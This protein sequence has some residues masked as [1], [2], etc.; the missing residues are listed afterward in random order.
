MVAKKKSRIVKKAVP[1]PKDAGV[2]IDPRTDFGFKRLFGE[3]DLM[4]AFLNSVL[5][6]KDGI[7]DLEYRNTVRTGVSKDERETI[8][9]LY[10]ST[11]TGEQI[12]VEMQTIPHEHFID[13]V[14]YYVSRLIQQQGKK[15]KDWDY[16]LPPIYSVNIVDFKLDKERVEDKYLSYIQ[17]LDRDTKELLY[18]KLTLLFLELP[19]FKK[20]E[21]ELETDVD[22]WLFTLK[23]LPKL[24]KTP[25]KLGSKVFRKLFELAK[26]AKMTAEQQNDY[27]K[28]LHDMNIVKIQFGKMES[29]IAQQSKTIAV[30][31]H[32]ISALTHDNTALTHDISALQ[33][34]NEEL[35]R[36]L[37]LSGTTDT[38]P[39]RTTKVRVRNNVKARE[40]A[41]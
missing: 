23:N 20:D 26:I 11:G 21:D 37:G 41:N 18:D 27:Y 24:N 32:D 19:R 17:L 30:L 28:S 31:T 9:D 10:C 16:Q 25:K 4:I 22:K 1:K 2:Y 5:D 14:V 29:T 15:S 8:F 38:K 34:E 40:A 33:K 3:K 36:R 6:V 13:R 35:R 39:T 12:I 7:V